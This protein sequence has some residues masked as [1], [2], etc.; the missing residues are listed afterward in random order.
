ML[1][2]NMEFSGTYSIEPTPRVK[3]I[4]RISWDLMGQEV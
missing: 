4:A 3:G 1:R 2:D